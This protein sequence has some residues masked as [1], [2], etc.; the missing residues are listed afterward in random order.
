MEYVYAVNCNW[1][2][3]DNQVFIF[4]NVEDAILYA[5]RL[6]SE[7]VRYNDDF[8]VITDN[9]NE[10]CIQWHFEG[11]CITVTKEELR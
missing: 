3:T 2:N 9:E 10:Y 8:K 5:L 6:A 7:G 11:Y 1:R 4:K